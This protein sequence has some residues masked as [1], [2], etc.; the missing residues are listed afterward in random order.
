LN[1]ARLL[2]VEQ[3]A[4]KGQFLGRKT[5]KKHTL[6]IPSTGKFHFEDPKKKAG[7][8]SRKR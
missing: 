1:D 3:L 5:R 4:I 2:F 6:L 7:D 8:N